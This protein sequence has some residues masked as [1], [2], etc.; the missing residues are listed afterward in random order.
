MIRYREERGDKDAE[1]KR[2]KKRRELRR[3]IADNDYKGRG[4]K[5]RIVKSNRIQ[6]LPFHKSNSVIH[7][8]VYTRE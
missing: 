7:I 4:K 2:K 5:S 6:K 1:R 8:K 3:T